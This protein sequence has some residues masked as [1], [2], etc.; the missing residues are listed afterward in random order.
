MVTA[1]FIIGIVSFFAAPVI[2]M[3]TG[4]SILTADH[5]T[6]VVNRIFEGNPGTP[7][8]GAIA[9]I[10]RGD[11]SVQLN[12]ET[13]GMIPRQWLTVYCAFGYL[14]SM[15]CATFSNVAFANE[16]FN[17][18]NGR[19]V[20]VRSGLRFAWSR[21]ASILVWS[22][23]AGVIGIFIQSL[24]RRFG[25]VGKILL[26]LVGVVWSVASVFAIPVIVRNP[27]AN[28]VELL[29]RSALTLRRTWG[30][31]LIG[32]VG[33]QFATV[34]V[35]LASVACLL[36]T[37]VPALVHGFLWIAFAGFGLWVIFV[38]SLGYV[39][40]VAEQIYRCALY[41]YASEG[42]VP[43][44]FSPEMMNMAWKIKLKPGGDPA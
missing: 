10:D 36:V 44:P 33:I 13:K 18:L 23:F 1:V 15:F 7:I 3:P 4:H 17:A 14:A 2:L 19:A 41:V 20:S 9:G 8:R 25:W 5:W 31:A 6:A 32:Y 22:L 43:G 40:S 28:P 37:A 39:S 21:V 42:V 34:L 26:S 38:I 11:D 12:W 35:I 29:R 27:T 24:E 30:E 16:I